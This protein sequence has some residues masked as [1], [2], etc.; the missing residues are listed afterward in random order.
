[1][2]NIEMLNASEIYNKLKET[3]IGQDDYLKKLAVLGYKHQLNIVA[4]Q[5]GKPTM[6]NNLLVVG[7]TG[8]GKTYAV[9]TLAK[10]I[11]IPV[12]EVDCSNLVQTGYKGSLSVDTMM[13]NFVHTL[14]KRRSSEAIVYLDE[15]DKI[16]DQYL[17]ARG[18]GKG[19]MQNFLKILERNENLAVKAD[20]RG[21][22]LENFDNSC[23]T[24]VATGSFENIKEKIRKTKTASSL[25]G[26]SGKM[27][28]VSKKAEK[29]ADDGQIELT[30]SDIVSG[31]FIPELIGR[32]NDIVNIRKLSEEDIYNIIAHGKGSHLEQVSEILKSQG[33][34]LKVEESVYRDLAKKA[35]MLDTGARGIASEFNSLIE[36]CL[37]DASS[38]D[39]ISCITIGFKDG[40]PTYS[41]DHLLHQNTISRK[42]VEEI[43]LRIV[44][45][46]RKDDQKFVLGMYNAGE[47]FGC[48]KRQ[49]LCKTH[50]RL[51]EL[52]AEW[53]SRSKDIVVDSID[54]EEARD[55]RQIQR[56]YRSLASVYRKIAKELESKFIQESKMDGKEYE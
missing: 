44:S 3:V 13:S 18:E 39:S 48:L 43:C 20:S 8:C 28:F 2:E 42:E 47:V 14:G 1:M 35:A 25:L 9:K 29:S 33:I 37:F 36:G 27:G 56:R 40:V 51:L 4:K 16:Y 17:D 52:A 24:F 46:I 34:E 41:Y 5:N 49:D 53:E 38:D 6:N 15:F 22:E 54:P 30:G 23:V 55:N 26:S 45:N 12:Y 11:D 19:A 31:G 50:D 7:P 10:I 32:F 21:D